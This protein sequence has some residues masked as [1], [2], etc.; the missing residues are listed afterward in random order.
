[1]PESASKVA[2]NST[3]GVFPLPPQVK[4][5][6]LITGTGNLHKRS[7]TRESLEQT[8]LLH[9][10]P[11]RQ[12]KKEKKKKQHA[13]LIHFISSSAKKKSQKRIRHSTIIRSELHHLQARDSIDGDAI[14]SLPRIHASLRNS[15]VQ[16]SIQ[17]L[18]LA[19]EREAL[20]VLGKEAEA[21][22][23][24]AE[25][26]SE[27]VHGGSEG[28]KGKERAVQRRQLRVVSRVRDFARYSLQFLHCRS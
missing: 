16:T 13:A 27:A 21:V 5:P 4:F 7:A 2:M 3:I 10:W 26:E 18:K 19:R 15:R 12:K 14:A 17:A 20:P 25:S 11:K 23:M 28:Q 24:V 8:T 9:H 1:M 6:T 22:E